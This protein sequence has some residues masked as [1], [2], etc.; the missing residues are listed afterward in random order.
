MVKGPARVTVRGECF[1]LG[2]NV[3]DSVIK[4]RAG[5]ALPFEVLPGCRLFVSS[6][7]RSRCWSTSPHQAGTAIWKETAQ[8]VF[9]MTVR[10]S[11]K[12]FR[13]MIAGESDSG[14]S[15]MC[16]YLSNLAISRGSYPVVIDGDIGQGDIAPPCS[17]GAAV[18][19]SPVTDLRDA[20]ATMFEFVGTISAAGAETE[21]AAS[22][23]AICQRSK[24]LGNFQ[25]VNTDGLV[26]DVGVS[27]KRLIAEQ[28]EPDVIV[29]M[30]KNPLLESALADRWP[31]LRARSSG[32]VIKSGVERRWRRYDQYLRFAGDGQE[33]RKT[34]DLQI[35]YRGRAVEPFTLES[36]PPAFKTGGLSGIFAGLGTGPRV[37]GFGIIRGIKGDDVEFQ[38][39]T[40][41]FDTVF[42]SSIRIVGATAEQ[43]TA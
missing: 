6:S 42:L 35:F 22:L 15:T 1:V 17:I 41:H 24:N 25:I 2:A 10:Q 21:I 32:Q 3:S 16:T 12:P 30:G 14:K 33:L 23:G 18:L 43:I 31:L 34:T 20:T 28:V 8:Q 38:T 39:D 7:A 13:I 9:A 5:K 11:E 36:L 29:C 26:H 37:S 40:M 27:Y 19:G 4:V